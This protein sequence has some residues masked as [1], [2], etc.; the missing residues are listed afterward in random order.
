[1]DW[2][3]TTQILD[4]AIQ[5]VSQNVSFVTPVFSVMAASLV[6]S[7]PDLT[8]NLN[9][10][11]NCEK[12]HKNNGLADTLRGKYSFPQRTGRHGS[13]YSKLTKLATNPEVDACN[14]I[15]GD[16]IHEQLGEKNPRAASRITS[17][18]G[19][20]HDNVA[21][22]ACGMGY[23]AVQTYSDPVA[24]IVFAIADRGRGMLRNVQKVSPSIQTHSDAIK[25]CLY[26]GNT[27]AHNKSSWDQ[28]LPE[29]YIINPYP[30]SVATSTCENHHMG[31]GLSK[32]AE[33]VRDYG[34][35]LWI[36]SGNSHFFSGINGDTFGES[37]LKWD[38]VA[39]EFEIPIPL[40]SDS[41]LKPRP[42]LEELGKRTGI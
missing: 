27:T 30:T 18:V 19:E 4:N 25:W 41:T 15:V 38:G 16:L 10:A 32:L 29:D 39:I 20:L 35:S 7:A 17:V 21:S 24:R 14:V 42:D 34:G 3:S 5:G 33:L 13:T 6:A 2:P 8:R 37:R 40:S 26:P 9:F 23:S 22:H 11:G 36:L 1:M 28:R 31:L 12:Y